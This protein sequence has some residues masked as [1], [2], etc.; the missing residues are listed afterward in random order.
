MLY[1][2]LLTQLNPLPKRSSAE[3]L[4]DAIKPVFQEK[5]QVYGFKRVRRGF[6]N[7]VGRVFKNSRKGDIQKNYKDG[8][9]TFSIA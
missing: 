7:V 8:R 9:G 4:L 6:I 2:I 1:K 5:L 3:V